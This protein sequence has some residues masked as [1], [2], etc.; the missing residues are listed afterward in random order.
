MEKIPQSIDRLVT[1][2]VDIQ[3]DFVDGSLAVPEATRILQPM[4]QLLAYTRARGGTVALTR[5]WHP[6]TTKHFDVWPSHCVEGTNGAA[7][8]E[9]LATEPSDIII[10]KGT[11]TIDDGYSG[12]EGMSGAGQ[13]LEQLIRP[14][15]PR[16]R[17]GVLLGGLATDYCVKATILDG[18]RTFSDSPNVQFA[19]AVDAVRGVEIAAGDSQAAL[20]EMKKAGARFATNNEITNDQ[21]FRVVRSEYHE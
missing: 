20:N 9:R 2:G 14:R 7:F 19:L 5:D 4:N 17:V 10:S 1:I 18:L 15:T 6:E 3:N 11:S 12:F 8:H 21:L 16:E 13:T